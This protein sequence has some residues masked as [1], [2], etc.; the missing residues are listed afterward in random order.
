[1]QLTSLLLQIG[2]QPKMP[3][4]QMQLHVRHGNS[5]RLQVILQFLSEPL[6]EMPAALVEQASLSMHLQP[7][8]QHDVVYST[9]E[10][11]SAF[12]IVLAGVP[13]GCNRGCSIFKVLRAAS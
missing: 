5:V 11:P 12:Y 8:E 6:R 7:F 1:M 9:G 13:T 10:E 4:K 2:L 3:R